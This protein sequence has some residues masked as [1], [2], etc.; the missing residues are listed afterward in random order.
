MIPAAPSAHP[1]HAARP[2][3]AGR[4]SDGVKTILASKAAAMVTQAVNHP[5]KTLITRWQA[6]PEKLRPLHDI[7]FPSVTPG[8]AQ[9]QQYIRSSYQGIGPGFAYKIGQTGIKL[10]SQQIITDHVTASDIG[11]Q[12]RVAYGDHGEAMIR[13]LAGSAG[14]LLELMV[15]PLDTYM[16]KRQADPALQGMGTRDAMRQVGIRTLFNGIGE[17]ALRNIQGS[18]WAFYVSQML[19]LEMG[20]R[21]PRNTPSGLN[22]ACNLGGTSASILLTAPFDILKVRKQVHPD[23]AALNMWQ[24]ARNIVRQEGVSGLWKGALPKVITAAPRPAMAMT[25]AS[26]FASWMGVEPKQPS[27]T[28]STLPA[29]SI[30]SAAGQTKVTPPS[31]VSPSSPASPLSQ[32]GLFG[33]H[34]QQHNEQPLLTPPNDER[35]PRNETNKRM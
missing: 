24:L 9:W 2:S 5:L 27:N 15:Y 32:Q 8:V 29:P 4:P 21:D 23:L 20:Y 12:W 17:T 16:V 22:F 13:G 11:K 35:N 18:F 33:H 28:A 34:G 14:G 31:P 19:R 1:S 26:M 10:A 7:L 25:L 6:N 3:N 30:P